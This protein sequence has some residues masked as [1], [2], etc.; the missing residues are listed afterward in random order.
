V[1]NKK[2]TAY[3]APSDAELLGAVMCFSGSIS[4]S[5]TIK[6]NVVKD[7]DLSYNFE[8]EDFAISMIVIPTEK[9]THPSGSILI[10]KQGPIEELAIDLNGNVYAYRASN[11]LPYKLTY[12]SGSCKVRFEKSTGVETFAISS[13]VSM[14]L[15]TVHHVVATKSGSLMTL[16]VNSPKASS[17]DS[18]TITVGDR[19]CANKSNIYVGNSDAMDQGFTGIIDNLKLYKGHLTS[20][21]VKILHHTLGVGNLHVGN[22]FYNHGMMILTGVPI[23]YST[24]YNIECRGSHTIYENEISCTVNPGDFGMSSNPTLQVYDSNLNQ[25]VYS[26]FVTGSQFKPF[27]TTVGLYND[28]GD[29]LVV[30]KLNT[31]VQLPDN[32]D[33]TIIVRYDR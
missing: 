1:L 15:N 24:I 21:D 7:Y 2:S 19:L 14:S 23:R 29:L 6:P 13:S 33:T 11:K 30:G 31:P 26:S 28:Q 22:A 12:T 4:S 9:P 20:N 17:M 10:T 25:F 3:P 18:A 27:V 16:Y 8:N 5:L 32:M